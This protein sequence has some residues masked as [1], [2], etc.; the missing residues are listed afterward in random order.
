MIPGIVKN[1]NTQFQLQQVNEQAYCYALKFFVI[2]I[3]IK[4]SYCKAM[5]GLVCNYQFIKKANNLK[6]LNSKLGI[7]EFNS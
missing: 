7:I 1:F 3:T 6:Q 5:Y 2:I 4:L